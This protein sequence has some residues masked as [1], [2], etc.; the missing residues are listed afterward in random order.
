MSRCVCPWRVLCPNISKFDHEL[1]DKYGLA[2]PTIDPSW[3]CC[4]DAVVRSVALSVRRRRRRWLDAADV[5]ANYSSGR[6]C[7][8]YHC[9]DATHRAIRLVCLSV[10][11]CACITRK[12][13][14]RTLPT[15][16]CMLPVVMARSSSDGIAICYLLPILRMTPLSCH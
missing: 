3:A 1:K 4:C 7:Y 14:G 5:I 13:H 8:S 16:L 6:G 11:L 9:D 15:F 2:W 12:L 10:C